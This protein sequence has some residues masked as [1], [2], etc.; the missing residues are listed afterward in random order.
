MRIVKPWWDNVIK[1]SAAE[2]AYSNL[3]I[4]PEQAANVAKA[5][6]HFETALRFNPDSAGVRANRQLTRPVPPKLDVC[7]A[8]GQR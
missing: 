7:W 4:V 8:S 2:L 5:I 1:N 6:R 3:G